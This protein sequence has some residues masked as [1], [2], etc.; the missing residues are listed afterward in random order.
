MDG[1]IREAINLHPSNIDRED[2]LILSRS[3]KPLTF[4]DG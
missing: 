4:W 1:L 3:W 2:D